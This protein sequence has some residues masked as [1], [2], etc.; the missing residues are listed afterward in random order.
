MKLVTDVFVSKNLY[1]P[2][3]NHFPSSK[4]TL[5]IHFFG[6]TCSFFWFLFDAYGA[7]PTT[8]T[9]SQVLVTVFY[10]LHFLSCTLHMYIYSKIINMP[11]YC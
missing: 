2:F 3:P 1:A 6:Y 4:I 11:A 5:W 9:L 8:H 10:F 7:L